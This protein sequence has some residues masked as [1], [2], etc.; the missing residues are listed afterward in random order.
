[1]NLPNKLTLLRIILVPI[2]VIIYYL[3]ELGI[4]N[5]TFLNIAITNWIILAIFGIASYTDHLDGKLA[6]R[7]NLIT[8]FGKFADPLPDKILV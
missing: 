5:G 1:M 7:D 8:T 4:I 3:G 6:R 2:I